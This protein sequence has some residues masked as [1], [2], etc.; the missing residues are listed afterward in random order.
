MELKEVIKN[1]EELRNDCAYY[2]QIETKDTDVVALS[3]AIEILK[4]TAQEVPVQ[5]QSVDIVI[6]CK[7]PKNPEEILTG[8]KN[9]LRNN[10]SSNP[11]NERLTDLI[12]PNKSVNSAFIDYL[13]KCVINYQHQM[14][15][16]NRR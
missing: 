13:Y 3:A 10:F 1:L 12:T 16:S 7:S 8:I 15:K 5:E 2:E 11:S 6:N 4:R 9:V 14:Q